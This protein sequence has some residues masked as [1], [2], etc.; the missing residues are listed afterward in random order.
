MN[1]P[2]KGAR[3]NVMFDSDGSCWMTCN[4][5]RDTVLLID[6]GDKYWGDTTVA[7]IRYSINQMAPLRARH[8]DNYDDS[9]RPEIRMLPRGMNDAASMQVEVL[10]RPEVVQ[11]VKRAQ[12]LGRQIVGCDATGQSCMRALSQQATTRRALLVE[13]KQAISHM[14]I[15]ALQ[16][17]LGVVNTDTGSASP[18]IMRCILTPYTVAAC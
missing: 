10:T 9:L 7:N 17:L 13:Y 11:Q 12:D 1:A 3:P 5:R 16:H 18:D 6:Y 4:V 14:G 8:K 15:G 2:Y